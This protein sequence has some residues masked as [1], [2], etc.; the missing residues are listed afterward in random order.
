MLNLAAYASKSL[1]LK[2]LISAI[3]GWRHEK[4]GP[5]TVAWVE[6]IIPRATGTKWLQRKKGKIQIHVWTNTCYVSNLSPSLS[7]EK[8]LLQWITPARILMSFGS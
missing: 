8:L 6:V 7:E 5:R 2:G 3:Y 4:V 1:G